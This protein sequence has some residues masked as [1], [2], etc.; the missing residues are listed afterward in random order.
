MARP[1]TPPLPF[2][3]AVSLMRT[4]LQ[5]CQA[6]W[7]LGRQFAPLSQGGGAV[8]LVAL[9]ME[10]PHLTSKQWGKPVPPEPHRLVADIDPSLEQQILDPTKRER[11]ADVEQHRQTDHLG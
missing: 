3:G 6:G 10:L 9:K 7:S 1:R 8:C 5:T 11:I 4:S 2:L